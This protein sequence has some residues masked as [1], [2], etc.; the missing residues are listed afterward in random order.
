MLS[1]QH[2]AVAPALYRALQKARGLIEAGERDAAK[3]CG[4]A[5]AYLQAQ[6]GVRVEYLQIVD[7]EEMQP[8]ESIAGPV[9]IAA[10]IWFGSTRLIDSLLVNPK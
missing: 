4:P 5:L 2:R 7:P 8:V 6:P 1:R 3:V 10:A 9:L